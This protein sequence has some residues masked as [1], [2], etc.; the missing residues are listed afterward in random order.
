MRKVDDDDL[1]LVVERE[2][3]LLQADV[4]RDRQR[5]LSLLHPDFTEFGASGRVWSRDSI[6]DVTD[7]STVDIKMSDCEARRLGSEA[8]LLTY[9]S[10]DGNR[11][12]L[13]S[14]TWVKTSGAWLLLF[15]QGTLVADA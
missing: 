5:V 12:A 4:R 8:V 7:T 10:H 6:S 3:L 2:H 13:R 1:R 11:D 15:H 14:S 9:H